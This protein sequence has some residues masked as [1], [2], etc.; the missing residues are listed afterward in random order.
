MTTT[1]KTLDT[2]A[3]SSWIVAT[4]WTTTGKD[5]KG[6]PVGRVDIL[7]RDRSGVEREYSYG[8]VPL[9]WYGSLH[10]SPSIGRAYGKIFRGPGQGW[11]GRGVYPPTPD[12]AP[13]PQTTRPTPHRRPARPVTLP[14]RPAVAAA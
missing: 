9:W 13:T 14:T 8:E 11:G 6:M 5:A 4:T 10:M 2:S 7:M 3:R 12:F 1:P